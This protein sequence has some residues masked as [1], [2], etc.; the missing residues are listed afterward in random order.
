MSRVLEFLVGFVFACVSPA[1]AGTPNLRLRHLAR[2]SGRLFV[3]WS[4]AVSTVLGH[5]AELFRREEFDGFGVERQAVGIRVAESAGSVT[6]PAAFH[7]NR[8]EPE[9]VTKT[10]CVGY[11]E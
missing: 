5:G 11:W 6:P 8:R 4:A 9:R 2:I 1:K 3:A 10:A 7:S